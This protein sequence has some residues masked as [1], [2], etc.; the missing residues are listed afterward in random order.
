MNTKEVLGL[1]P[2]RTGFN[3]IIFVPALH[4]ED[5]F[6]SFDNNIDPFNLPNSCGLSVEKIVDDRL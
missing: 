1:K 6:S 5:W 2:T 3:E 4:F